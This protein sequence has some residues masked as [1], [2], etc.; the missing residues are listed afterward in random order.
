M[1]ISKTKQASSAQ[2]SARVGSVVFRA[3]AS[4]KKMIQDAAALEKMDISTYVRRSALKQ[5]EVDLTTRREFLVSEEE[6]E[7]FLKIL[8]RP[9]QIKPSL[10]A[11]L[12]EEIEID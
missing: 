7:E 1:Q 8:A 6:M 2:P 12:L 5:A 9:E 10:K 3:T 4:E 11:L